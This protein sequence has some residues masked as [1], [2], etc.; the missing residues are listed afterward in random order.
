M[1]L[2]KAARP[3]PG[4]EA[5]EWLQGEADAG[6]DADWR[7]PRRLELGNFDAA[8]MGRIELQLFRIGKYIG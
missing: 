4:Q 1:A 6:H 2:Q 5:G 3:L 8:Y 7:S